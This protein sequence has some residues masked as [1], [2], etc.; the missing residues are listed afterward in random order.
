MQI[1]VANNHIDE[2]QKAMTMGN[3]RI[4]W[5]SLTSAIFVCLRAR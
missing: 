1:F 3:L 2:K 4:Y 5:Q